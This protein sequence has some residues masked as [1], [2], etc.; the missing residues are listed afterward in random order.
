MNKLVMVNEEHNMLICRLCD[1]VVRPDNNGIEVHFRTHQVK[2]QVLKDVVNYYG[3]MQFNDPLTI[4]LPPDGTT[5]VERLQRLHGFS[6]TKYHATRHWTTANHM[7]G[8]DEPRWTKV[9]LQSWMWSQRRHARYW[10]VKD[11]ASEARLR[12]GDV[13]EGLDRDSAW[14][15]RV[16]WVRHFGSRDKLEV[17]R[18][19]EWVKAKEAKGSVAASRR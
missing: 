9:E 18:A 7:A 10:V 19:A 15:K 17:H 11:N 6:C 12:K 14:V 1:N 2:G 16:G 13:E 5:P 4:A 3:T 8:K